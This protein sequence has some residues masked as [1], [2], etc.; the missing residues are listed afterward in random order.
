MSTEQAPSEHQADGTIPVQNMSAAPTP[1]LIHRQ[2]RSRHSDAAISGDVNPATQ[3]GCQ[4]SLPKQRR[5]GILMF[6]IKLLQPKSATSARKPSGSNSVQLGDIPKGEV[7]RTYLVR[8]AGYLTKTITRKLMERY[9]YPYSVT[10]SRQHQST[11][12]R[13]QP[14]GKNLLKVL[15]QSPLW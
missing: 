2:S 4:V 10:R 9:S 13:L 3:T 1:R 5:H 12:V 14:C 15:S 8:A 6:F 11:A 7:S